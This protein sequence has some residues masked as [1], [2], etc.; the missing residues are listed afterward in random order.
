MAQPAVLAESV[1]T[2]LPAMCCQLNRHYA[3]CPNIE[4]GSWRPDSAA[5]YYRLLASLS[6]R[7]AVR[8]F[9]QPGLFLLPR[10]C[11]SNIKHMAIINTRGLIR[12]CTSSTTAIGFRYEMHYRVASRADEQLSSIRT[13]GGV[14]E[15]GSAPEGSPERHERTR[16]S[17][18]VVGEPV[19]IHVHSR[20][21][22]KR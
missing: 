7:F 6:S 19:I 4:Y 3:A 1:H 14:P 13:H 2:S 11:G 20:H 9:A 15:P 21:A 12:L 18:G 22:G 5:W 17:P 16:P 8:I 10:Q